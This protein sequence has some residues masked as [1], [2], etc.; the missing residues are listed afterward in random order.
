[1]PILSPS[2]IPVT[3]VHPAAAAAATASA[4]SSTKDPNTTLV[5]VVCAWPV[6]GQYGPGTRILYYVLV[7]ACVFARKAAWLRSACLAAALLLPAVAALHAI[8]LAILHV[9]DVVDMDIYGAFQL[10][11]IGVLAA[12][13]TVGA[14]STYF[15]EPGRNLIFLWT[16]LLLAGLLSL[17]VEFYRSGPSD[18]LVDNEFNL[19]KPNISYLGDQCNPSCV[20]GPGGPYSPLR[21]GSANNIYVIPIP[22]RLTFDAGT[23]LAAACCIPAI[24]S[25]I[26]TWNRILQI[27]WKQRPSCS[28]MTGYG[29]QDDKERLN[30]PIVGTNGAT[31]GKMIN[32]NDRIKGFIYRLVAPVFGGAILGILVTGERNFFSPQVNYQ[33]EPMTSVGQ[34]APV[35]GTALAALGSLYV[36]IATELKKA[37]TEE[38]P[39][40]PN[41][42]AHSCNC[43]LNYYPSIHVDDGSIHGSDIENP[44]RI[45]SHGSSRH[46]REGGSVTHVESA[47]RSLPGHL[48]QTPTNVDRGNRHKFAKMLTSIGDYV[49]TAAADRFDDSEFRRG[50]AVDWPL[51]P[52][53][54]E[55][56]PEL[57]RIQQLYNPRRDIE[58]NATPRPSRPAS[59]IGTPP[60]EAPTTPPRDG[61]PGSPTSN[62]SPISLPPHV[63]TRSITLPGRQTPSQPQ[64]S[65]P[66][67]MLEYHRRRMAPRRDT[68]EVPSPMYHGPPRSSP[69]VSPPVSPPGVANLAEGSSSPAIYVSEGSAPTRTPE[70]TPGPPW[71]GAGRES[72]DGGSV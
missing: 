3:L 1:M 50:R 36:L 8:V 58:G 32:V 4:I 65:P 26:F 21:Q 14:S 66:I 47:A 57:R 15:N 62:R 53:E 70:S 20:V 13:A 39:D 33:T 5:Q 60:E 63:V 2:P 23:L 22:R 29:R 68:L 44:L 16:G 41:T 31:E 18:C 7:A 37:E 69:P 9:D 42:H 11:A 35:V 19:R 40:V 24:L 27:N 67:P 54:E 6:S 46:S 43:S 49:G 34:W 51:I 48:T 30:Q 52:G 38:E 64:T 25:L 17:T 71:S 56:N 55:R 12:P 45:I 72:A 10:C 59:F 28:Y 61:S